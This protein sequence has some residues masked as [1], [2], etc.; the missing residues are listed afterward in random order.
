MPWLLKSWNYNLTLVLTACSWK[1]GN[2][3]QTW[4]I[5]FDVKVCM[6]VL[7]RIQRELHKYRVLELKS[8]VFMTELNKNFRLFYSDEV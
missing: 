6:E 2:N 7:V 3:K 4:K 8:T 1:Y 5:G